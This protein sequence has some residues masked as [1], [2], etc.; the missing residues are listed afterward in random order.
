[1]P[2]WQATFSDIRLL[3]V[4]SQAGPDRWR[5]SLDTVIMDCGPHEYDGRFLGR[6]T[7]QLDMDAPG[8]AARVVMRVQDGPAA[9]TS[10]VHY[11]IYAQPAGFMGLFV[12]E[13]TL[14][15]RQARMVE[16]YLLDLAL[17]FRPA[18]S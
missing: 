5:L 4:V 11:Q 12:P 14:R 15:K 2:A 18:G 16:R 6:R 9:G 8:V 13:S 7:L 17:A 3:E 10:T 1:M